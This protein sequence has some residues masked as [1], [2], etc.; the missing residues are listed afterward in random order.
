MSGRW[1]Q[2]LEYQAR[3]ARLWML[4]QEPGVNFK[5]MLFDPDHSESQPQRE[6]WVPFTADMFGPRWDGRSSLGKKMEFTA[7]PIRWANIM[8]PRRGAL[9]LA[10]PYWVSQPMCELVEAA[11]PTM[12]DEPLKST[13]LPARTGFVVFESPLVVVR[14]DSD[15]RAY[16]AVCWHVTSGYNLND[17]ATPDTSGIGT[18]WYERIGHEHWWAEDGTPWPFGARASEWFNAPPHVGEIVDAPLRRLLKAF[19]TLSSQRI[20]VQTQVRDLP[21]HIRRQ[22]DRVKLDSREVSLVTLRRAG[23]PSHG[24]EDD[25]YNPIDWTHRWIVSGHWRNQWLPSVNDHRLQWISPYV[26]GPED[27]PLVVKQR[28]YRWTR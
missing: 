13:D 6:P 19:W 8:Q 18:W 27:R 11:G 25:E 2:T 23:A 5:G 21:R 10:T 22:F 24:P 15:P 1:W 17:P 7:D 26:K 16:V 28:L 12:P 20:A 3:L 9:L 14:Q 4:P